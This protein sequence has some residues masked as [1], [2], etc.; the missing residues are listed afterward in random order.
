MWA[1]TTKATRCCKAQKAEF[2]GRLSLADEELKVA[3]TK[4]QTSETKLKREKALGGEVSGAKLSKSRTF[5]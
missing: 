2:E 1:L 4:I 3:Q 5:F